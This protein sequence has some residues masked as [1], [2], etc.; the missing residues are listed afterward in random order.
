MDDNFGKDMIGFFLA[1]RDSLLNGTLSCYDNIV[2]GIDYKHLYNL[3]EEM[4]W[5]HR[6]GDV[7]EEEVL[8]YELYGAFDPWCQSILHVKRLDFVRKNYY[9]LISMGYF[10]IL[11]YI[12][13]VS[14][15]L[16]FSCSLP[17]YSLWRAFLYAVLLTVSLFLMKVVYI[18]Y[19]DN[20]YYKELKRMAKKLEF[21]ESE[22]R[23]VKYLK[24][25][26]EK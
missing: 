4:I 17:D 15:F 20:I 12:G 19:L 8:R 3:E 21:Q 7:S 6:S 1:D 26:E 23:R 10:G 13:F 16:I 14:F 9:D 25:D 24:K 2:N 18:L 5:D 22:Y 11:L